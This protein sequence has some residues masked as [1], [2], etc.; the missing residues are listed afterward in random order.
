[1]AIKKLTSSQALGRAV[2]VVRAGRG[3][4]QK[5][6]ASTV[7][8]DNCYISLIE[9]GF[10]SPSIRVLRKLESILEVPSGRLME[11]AE[12]FETGRWER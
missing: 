12:E 6:V 10:R 4:G 7:G 9:N 5:Q 1:M 2:A 11:L 8:V 3:L